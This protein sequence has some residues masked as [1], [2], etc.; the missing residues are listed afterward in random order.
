MDFDPIFDKSQ[1]LWECLLQPEGDLDD[2][3]VS[4]AH[5]HVWGLRNWV[6]FC[7]HASYFSYY[8]F[9]LTELKNIIYHLSQFYAQSKS[10]HF[11]IWCK[12]NM[13]IYKQYVFS[14]IWNAWVEKL[15]YVMFNCRN[16]AEL[17]KFLITI[18]IGKGF[19]R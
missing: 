6:L 15:F 11:T 8:F 19:I 10:L 17:N 5:V 12:N 18:N 13:Q 16:T 3:N 9:P 1:Q 14:Q 7:Q 4:I 2:P